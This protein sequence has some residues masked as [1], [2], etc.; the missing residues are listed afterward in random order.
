M[1]SVQTGRLSFIL[2]PFIQ[3]KP[4]GNQKLMVQIKPSFKMEVDIS[5][6]KAPLLKK[7]M[8]G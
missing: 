4:Y 7:W 6:E 5:R 1:F 3:V 8:D 2:T